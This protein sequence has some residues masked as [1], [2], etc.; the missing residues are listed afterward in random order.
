MNLL[1]V[2]QGSNLRV[3]LRLAELLRK[4][5]GL[6]TVSAYVADSQE[7]YALAAKEPVLSD[8]VMPIL[9]EWEITQKGSRGRPDWD[10][11]RKWEA[12][13]GDPVLWHA[14]MADRRIFYGRRCKFK[15]DYSPRFT[16]EQMYAIAQV[17]IERIQGFLD[18]HPPSVIVGFG[19]ST[20]GDYFFYRFA[21]HRGIPYL[22]LKA[23]KIGNFVAL[24]D[25]AIALSGHIRAFIDAPETISGE[26][27][28]VARSHMIS[29]RRRGVRY[30]GALKSPARFRPFRAV[31]GVARGM[32]RDI[33]NRLHPV[34][35]QDNHVD[36]AALAALY[37]HLIQPTKAAYVSQRLN[38]RLV[39]HAQLAMQPPYAF[40]PLH[41]EP[42]VALQVFGR[43]YQNQIELIRNLAISLPAGM[44]LLV[45]EHPRS[46]GFRPYGY[47]RKLMQIPNVRL[48]DPLIPT[49][50]VI[51]HASLVAV[52]SGST[53]LE[54]AVIGK[55]V[56]TFGVPAYN[57]LPRCMVRHV[58]SLHD[59]AD[60][61]RDL[62]ENYR[63]DE[64]ALERFL[65]AHVAG[66][67]P[68][69]LYSV[70]L[71]KPGRHSEGREEMSED[72][73]RL[74]DYRRLSD[75]CS[76]RIL[77]EVDRSRGHAS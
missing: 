29:I 18:L 14:L 23:T 68:V 48:V 24:N 43:P 67:V 7:F 38:H 26:A 53:G 74:E 39:R 9:K 20:F 63:L 2:T 35:G 37:S 15:Q 22:Q 36:S 3:F 30:E 70:L 77:E 21:R 42:E 66:A 59:L 72:E 12:A 11:L 51:Q 6:S 31:R 47:Y 55:P 61:V 5:L 44:L 52:I 49:H 69:D 64:S 65:A 62:M 8:P 33:R 17:A 10:V 60:D 32:V 16:H 46:F 28:E 4:P 73:R 54:A 27:L 13:L 58:R 45:K 34:V 71:G 56:L 57:N 75:Y 50:G 41:F 76:G 19:T 25:D 1:G 40:Y